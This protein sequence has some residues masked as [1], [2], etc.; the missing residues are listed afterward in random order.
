MPNGARRLVH[1]LLR[2]SWTT[3][4]APG[5]SN[6]GFMVAGGMPQGCPASGAMFAAASVPLVQ[7]IAHAIG[8]ARTV[9]YADDVAVVLRRVSEL[10][11]IADILRVFAAAS[12]L[13]GKPS[14][15]VVIPLKLN[16]EGFAATAQ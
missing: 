4:C 1:A 16:A 2:P 15:C 8:E 5:E 6:A 12:G 11:K 10:R 7:M 14:K 3:V 13:R 9:A